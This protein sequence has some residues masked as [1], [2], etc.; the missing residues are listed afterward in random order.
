MVNRLLYS[1]ALLQWKLV[2]YAQPVLLLHIVQ[3]VCLFT[4]FVISWQQY[5]VFLQSTLPFNF[6]VNVRMYAC[7]YASV[8][9]VSYS[10][11]TVEWRIL[12]K[13]LPQV[14]LTKTTH[15]NRCDCMCTCIRVW[16]S[17]CVLTEDIRTYVGAYIITR[18]TV[19]HIGY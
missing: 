5:S 19:N 12:M 13:L 1:T 9:S 17:A 14:K 4:M 7:M 16:K 18:F 10:C 2:M 6:T 15:R 11:S 8:V 3:N